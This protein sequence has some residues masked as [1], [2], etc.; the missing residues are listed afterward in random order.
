MARKAFGDLIYEK[1]I[2][3]Q[4]EVKKKVLFVA[5]V[6]NHILAFHIPYLK[7]FKDEEFEVHVASNGNKEIPYCDKHFNINFSRSPFSR[8]NVVA[9]KKIKEISCASKLK[10]L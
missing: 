2:N 6:T 5:T 4:N 7:M 8:D 9:Y 3:S 1:D 10:R